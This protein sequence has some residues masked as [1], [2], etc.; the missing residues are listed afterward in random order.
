MSIYSAIGRGPNNYSSGWDSFTPDAGKVK[1]MTCRACGDKMKVKRKVKGPTSFG[2]A[3]ARKG[4]RHDHF[5]CPNTGTDWHNQ[6]IDLRNS[7]E[8]SPSRFAIIKMEE[9]IG[10][11]LQDRKPTLPKYTEASKRIA[12]YY[13]K[14]NEFK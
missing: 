5:F 11:I 3:I 8:D 4:H 6:L 9:E 1:K 2:E 10:F 13:K 12:K 7:V 14:K